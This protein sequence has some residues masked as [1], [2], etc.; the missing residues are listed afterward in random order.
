MKGTDHSGKRYTD[1][2]AITRAEY[3]QLL[4]L[5]T[6]GRALSEQTEAVIR[7]A[8]AITNETEGRNGYTADAVFE[9]RTDPKRALDYLLE[10]LDVAVVED[11]EPAAVAE[12]SE[13]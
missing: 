11:P 7:A 4:G 3:Y 13:E 1:K 6:L 9:T 8:T 12:G 10:R 2:T 5:L